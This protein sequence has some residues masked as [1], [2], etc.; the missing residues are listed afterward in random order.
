VS[1]GKSTLWPAEERL[2]GISWAALQTVRVRVLEALEP[3]LAG[4]E[5]TRVLTSLLR[6]NRTWNAQERIVVA[7]ALLGV[8]LWRRRLS[9]HAKEDSPDAL[10]D[11][12][13]HQLASAPASATWFP[14]DWPTRLSYPDWLAAELSHAL[15]N[16]AEAFAAASNLPGPITIRANGLRISREVLAK[17]LLNE[18]VEASFTAFAPEG[19]VLH[20]RP[21]VLG[22]PSHQAGLFEVQDGGSQLVGLCLEAQPEDSVLDLCAGSGGKTLLLGA[23]LNDTGRL[24]AYDV[25]P[26]SL[27]RLEHRAARAGIKRSLRILPELPTGLRA[28]RVLVDAPCSA[29]GVLRRGPDVRWRL[30]PDS[31]DA[32]SRLQA[33][34]LEVAASH[35]AEAGRVV[36]ATCTIRPEENEDLVEQFLTVHPE[37]TREIAPVPKELRTPRGDLQ[38]LPHRQGMDGFYAAVLRR[39]GS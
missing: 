32:F 7:E 10:L 25:N 36:Y 38:T 22:L 35:T 31:L 12:L 3:V 9:F 17:R 2:Q 37:F 18:G 28:N 21:N 5:A 8:A 14:E 27:E 33:E 4:A 30:S 29:L 1:P 24:Y 39:R 34:L 19:L 16:E 15:G 26:S 23:A 13:V 11:V 6:E 20:G